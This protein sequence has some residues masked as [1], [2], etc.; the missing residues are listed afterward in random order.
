MHG[1]TSYDDIAKREKTHQAR[2]I[3]IFIEH[4]YDSDARRWLMDTWA[5]INRDSKDNWDLLVPVTGLTGHV[6]NSVD[7]HLC[8]LI[9]RNYGLEDEDV[10]CIVLDNFNGS[11]NQVVLSLRGSDEDRKF[12]LTNVSNVMASE[13]VR[14]INRKSKNCREQMIRHVVKHLRTLKL[15]K[16]A[17]KYAPTAFSLF[18]KTALKIFFQKPPLP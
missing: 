6:P 12:L 1:I 17:V 10:P 11:R 16:D 9:R 7:I 5:A 8:D 3:G 2:L 18:T 4:G 15:R 14:E 13:T